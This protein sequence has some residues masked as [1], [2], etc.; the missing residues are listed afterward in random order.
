MRRRFVR[1]LGDP[2]GEVAAVARRERALELL[3]SAAVLGERVGEL[4]ARCRGRCRPRSAGSRRRRASCRGAS[5]PRPRAGRAPSTGAAPAWLTSRFASA[6]GRWLVSATQAVVGLPG[7]SRPAR[8]RARR[9]S[10]ARAGSAPG[11]SRASGV[12]NQV[13]PSKRSAAGVRRPA[14]LAR[15]RPGGR[16]RSARSGEPAAARRPSSSRRR[17]PC[18]P[19]ARAQDV[20]DNRRAGRRPGTATTA[21]SA[22]ASASSSARGLVERRRRSTA[23]AA[24]RLV[25][26]VAADPVD[27]RPLGGEA[28]DAPISPMPTMAT[29]L[30]VGHE[31]AT[32]IRASRED[33]PIRSMQRF[34]SANHAPKVS[35]C[36]ACGPSQSASSGA[37]VRPRR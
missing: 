34:T 28:D 13:A 12:R 15:R 31:A 36:R 30:I 29:G 4:V 18:T 20:V 24:A 6:C 27:A 19:R 26:V 32:A 3:D 17:S 14:R 33:L 16:R 35:A 11:R 8:R 10:R 37:R 23:A 1:G 7:R 22:S 21:R 25:G 2:A 9:R 5:R